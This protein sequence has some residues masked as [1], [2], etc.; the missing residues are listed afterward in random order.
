MADVHPVHVIPCGPIH[1]QDRVSGPLS[2]VN[3]LRWSELDW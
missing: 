3:V 2:R 1:P